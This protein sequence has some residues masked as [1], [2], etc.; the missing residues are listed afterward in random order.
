MPNGDS[1]WYWEVIADG[2]RVVGRGISE[3]EPAACLAASDAAKQ[4]K[5]IQ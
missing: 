1:R 4:A 5:L 3:T 2:G